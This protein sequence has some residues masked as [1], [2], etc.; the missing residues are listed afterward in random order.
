MKLKGSIL[1]ANYRYLLKP[2]RHIFFEDY[3]LYKI[4]PTEENLQLFVESWINLQYSKIAE[5]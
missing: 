3:K 4:D 5:R 2:A 1:K